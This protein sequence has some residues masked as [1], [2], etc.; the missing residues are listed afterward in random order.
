MLFAVNLIVAKAA[1]ILYKLLKN[2]NSDP[3]FFYRDNDE[4]RKN[5]HKSILN[6]DILN[7]DGIEQYVTIYGNNIYIYV[8]TVDFRHHILQLII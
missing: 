6:K 8:H 5:N 4:C 1:I 3:L 7:A 2:K